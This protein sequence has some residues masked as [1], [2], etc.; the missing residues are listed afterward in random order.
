MFPRISILILV[1]LPAAGCGPTAPDVSAVKGLM[2]PEQLALGA[3]IVNSI[4]MVLVPVPAGEFQMGT[5]TQE[6]P[7]EEQYAEFLKDA[8]VQTKLDSGETTE[9]DLKEHL[10]QQSKKR[11]NQQKKGGPETPQHL[12]KIT[13]PFYMG[14]C[15]VTQQQYEAVM[16]TKPWAE[17]PLVAEGADYAATY[18]SWDNAVEFCRKLSDQE[19]IEYRL[20][21]E[22]EW[23][24]ACR[25][26]TTTAYS[27]GDA[28]DQLS[29]YAWY[30]ANAYQAGEQ[31]AH[32]V[33]QKLPNTWALFDMHGNTWEWCSEW[34]AR[35]D[36]KQKQ[37]VDPTGPEK[38]RFR[39]WR[40]GSF[41]EAPDNM[42]SASRLSW[43]RV[44]YRPEY[45]AGFRVVR[46]LEPGP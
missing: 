22:A 44:D 7:L 28:R 12:V 6:K 43:D 36:G 20:P 1:M 37:T 38:G 3:P 2:A 5:S 11:S 26:G 29:E 19:G 45:L 15:E 14:V 27:F 31:Y 17:K 9:A 39:V 41:A 13:Q 46:V 16:G 4:D 32:G 40:G 25:S 42:R 34:Y 35:Y 30:D 33:G 10:K 23:E 24:Y 8:G 21:T 18:V